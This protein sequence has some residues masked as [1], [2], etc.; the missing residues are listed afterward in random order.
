[1]QISQVLA[2]L[3][4]GTRGTCIHAAST[5][6]GVIG[7]LDTTIM[8]ATPGT[9]NADGDEAFS[10][11]RE[12][13][14]RTAKSLVEDKKTLVAGAASNQE[15]L[16]SAAF[17]AVMTITQLSLCVKQGAAFL[18]S[19]QHSSISL[20]VSHAECQSILQVLLINA[21]KD[22]AS[23]L[24]EFISATKNKNI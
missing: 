22:V 11:H 9:L 13:I 2:A 1:I 19:E 14:L 21:V 12:N 24:G 17:S 7:D 5:V 18:G 4:A 8:F 23:A 16:A 10:D 6:S 15:Q 3:Q 20:T